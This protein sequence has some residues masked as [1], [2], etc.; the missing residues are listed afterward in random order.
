MQT[1][2]APGSPNCIQVKYDYTSKIKITF[3]FY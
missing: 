2:E 3:P 1:E